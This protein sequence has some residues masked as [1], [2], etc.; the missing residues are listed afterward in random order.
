MKKR[1]EGGSVIFTDGTGYI[2]G[3]S[4]RLNP[5]LDTLGRTYLYA[6]NIA[7]NGGQTQPVDFV[8]NRPLMLED[9]P[10]HK[11]EIEIVAIIASSSLIRYRRL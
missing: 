5:I 4:G 10:G 3:L 11:V 9:A 6:S 1:L 7:I 2:T 8:P